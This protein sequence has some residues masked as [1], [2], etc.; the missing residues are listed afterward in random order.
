MVMRIVKASLASRKVAPNSASAADDMTVLISWH[1]V[2]MATLLV[3]RV[4][5]LLPFLT[6]WLAT[7][8]CLLIGY[9]RV[10]HRYRTHIWQSLVSC[11]WH[12]S[13]M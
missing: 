1:R 12:D 9:A 5:G 4:G 8:N 13:G 7:K 2:W 11:C 3:G 10:L 6:S